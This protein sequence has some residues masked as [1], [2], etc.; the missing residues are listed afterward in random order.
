MSHTHPTPTPSNFQVIFEN[1]LNA[2]KRRTKED[3]LTHPLANQL[4]VCD[5]ASRILSVLQEQ[6]EELNQSQRRNER[7]TRWLYPTVKVLHAFGKD[8]THV[9]LSS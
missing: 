6:V 5:S 8:V 7:W 9:C 2:Y 3:L 1:A 4:E